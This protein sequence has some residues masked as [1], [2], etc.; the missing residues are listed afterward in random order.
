MTC[1]YRVLKVVLMCFYNYLFLNSSWLMQNQMELKFKKVNNK[2][3]I[4]KEYNEN[5][6][7]DAVLSFTELHA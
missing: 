7:L 3:I 1:T 2:V 5:P 4:S 6:H